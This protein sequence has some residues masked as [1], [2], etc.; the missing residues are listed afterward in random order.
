MR[1]HKEAGV[2]TLERRIGELCRK[3][4]REILESGKNQVR[5]TERNLTHYLGKE[6]YRYHLACRKPG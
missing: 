5:I 2:R 3:A 1:L 6:K 4:A